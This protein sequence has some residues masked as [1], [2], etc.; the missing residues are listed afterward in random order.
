MNVKKFSLG[1]EPR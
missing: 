1:C